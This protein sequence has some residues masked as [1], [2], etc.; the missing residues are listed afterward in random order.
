MLQ[1]RFDLGLAEDD[2]GRR[3]QIEAD[4]AGLDVRLTPRGRQRRDPFH[5]GRVGAVQQ[6]ENLHAEL[7]GLLR[8]PQQH[9][10]AVRRVDDDQCVTATAQHL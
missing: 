7:P 6:D 4:A 1:G 8:Q 5:R 2:D 9:V 3:L 10:L